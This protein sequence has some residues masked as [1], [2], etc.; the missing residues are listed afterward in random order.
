M[1]Y[2]VI[3]ER[4]PENW[5]AFAPDLPGYVATAEGLEELR[6]LCVKGYR[7]ISKDCAAQAIGF[8]NRRRS[9]MLSTSRNEP[10][11]HSD[12]MREKESHCAPPA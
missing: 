11:S 12:G 2:V 7:S 3:Y 1:K 5:G 9:S 8:P 10:S 6:E 4:D